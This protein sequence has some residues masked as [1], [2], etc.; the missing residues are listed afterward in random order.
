[1]P[2]TTRIKELQPFI[3]TWATTI[4]MTEDGRTSTHHATDVYR[5]ALGGKFV[6]HDVKGKMGGQP[7]ETLEVMSVKGSRNFDLRSY[8]NSGAIQDYTA[9]L[10]GHDWRIDGDTLRFRGAFSND[11][12]VLQGKWERRSGA[13]WRHWLVV[14]LERSPGNQ[15]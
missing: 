10:D 7:I 2:D 4:E 5:W 12:E 8:D 9:S 11:W 14:K 13:G 3:G 15:T 1:M 6:F